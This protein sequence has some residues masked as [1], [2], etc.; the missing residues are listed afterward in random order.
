[1]TNEAP[2]R[3]W[4]VTE[5][6]HSGKGPPHVYAS[7][8]PT[9]GIPFAPLAL[10]AAEREA[11]AEDVWHECYP[12]TSRENIGE[13]QLA[14]AATTELAIRA[15]RARTDADAQSA[16]EARD[17]RVREEALR[18][19][20]QRIADLPTGDSEEV[21]EGQYQSYRAIEALFEVK[22]WIEKDQVDDQD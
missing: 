5:P 22:P 17:K 3:I 4:I 19:A 20:L 21:T 12:S 18:E 10:M 13:I 16:L 7:A 9:K 8:S 1:M 2:E 6:H 14:E 15:I 11:C